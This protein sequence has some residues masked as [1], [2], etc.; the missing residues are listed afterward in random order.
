[1]RA[2]FNRKHSLSIVQ[3]FKASSQ[4]NP[5]IGVGLRHPH[6]TQSLSDLDINHSIDFVEIHAE[7]FF[8]KGGISRALLEDVCDK[9]NVSVHGTSLGLGSGL[10]VPDN[11]MNQFASVVE[12]SQA[13]LVSE[14]LC[15]NRAKVNKQVLHSGDLLPLAYNEA[16]L[17]VLAQNIDQVQSR[18]QRPILI[19]NLSA[20]VQVSE[21]EPIAQDEYSEMEFLIALCK[22]AGCG[23]L[24]DLNNLIV[25][26]LN[27]KIDEPHSH[28][29]DNIR[30]LPS[31]LI[32]EIHLAGFSPKQV[33]GFI[34]D[35][36]ASAVSAE[37]WELYKDAI[38][39]FGNV[40][41]LVEWDNDLPE[42][43]ILVSQA[44]RARDY[45]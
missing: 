1:M 38:A 2:A 23:L 22:Q 26:A 4:T 30:Q 13:F 27:Q 15:F 21:L 32:G 12:T 37:C 39:H 7:N 31:V 36:H 11:V 41:T 19:E 25:N 16:S 40:P 20:Y 43:D 33:N 45:C 17:N 3:A 10:A 5:I 28:I 18:L 42:W 29:F 14:H 35:D 24:L 44:Q 34:V 9:Y 8:A 6:Y